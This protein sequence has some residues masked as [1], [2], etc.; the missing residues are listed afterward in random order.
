M[1]FKIDPWSMSVKSWIGGC[2]SNAVS[3]VSRNCW[4]RTLNIALMKYLR[5]DTFKKNFTATATEVV[6][7]QLCSYTVVSKQNNKN[8]N[9]EYYGTFISFKSHLYSK[10]ESPIFLLFASRSIVLHL[11]VW[12]KSKLFLYF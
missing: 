10:Q 3:K 11:Y 12:V 2:L 1:N 7:V 4:E 6:L 5:N 9:K 8:E